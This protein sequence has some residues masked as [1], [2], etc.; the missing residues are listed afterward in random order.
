MTPS[1]TTPA[2]AP[3]P[4][5]GAEGGAAP[6]CVGLAAAYLQL[7]EV[8]RASAARD[9]IEAEERLRNRAQAVLGRLW[10]LGRPIP[11]LPGWQA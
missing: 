11:D 7:C 1:R 10:A 4:R 5:T 6:A 2:P 9:D 3:A 8:I